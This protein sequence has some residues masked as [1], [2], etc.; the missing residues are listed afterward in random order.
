MKKT[1]R[2]LTDIE[3]D[4][5][6]SICAVGA[7][8][9]MIREQTECFRPPNLPEGTVS[10]AADGAIK[11]LEDARDVYSELWS[12]CNEAEDAG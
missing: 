3:G 8:L 6:K 9:E 4:F 1:P 10:S 7:I 12:R 2:T 5:G 11:L